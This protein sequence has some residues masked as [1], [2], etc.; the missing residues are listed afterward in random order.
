MLPNF[1]FAARYI[2]G[3]FNILDEIN[4]RFLTGNMSYRA[5]VRE[6]A[7]PDFVV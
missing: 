5:T 6:E 4:F 7:R 2:W 3:H 1:K